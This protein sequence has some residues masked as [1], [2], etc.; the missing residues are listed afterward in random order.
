[1]NV[2]CSVLQKTIH[3]HVTSIV[4]VYLSDVNEEQ[5]HTNE[6]TSIHIL[7]E[8]SKKHSMYMIDYLSLSSWHK[9]I[10]FV[11]CWCHCNL[12]QDNDK[13]RV[14]STFS[15]TSKI[16]SILF[17]ILEVRLTAVVLFLLCSLRKF[18][19]FC[20]FHVVITDSL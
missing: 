12:L 7:L 17:L 6:C 20:W 18:L 9:M 5:M 19:C 15:L 10:S 16:R 2:C 11:F 4:R 13:K 1:M 8:Y 14:Y 3:G